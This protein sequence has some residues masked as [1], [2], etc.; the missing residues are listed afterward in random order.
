LSRHAYCARIEILEGRRLCAVESTAGAVANYGS[1]LGTALG[2]VAEW[3]DDAIDN[4]IHMP[5]PPPL[6]GDLYADGPEADPATQG[7]GSGGADLDEFD[8]AALDELYRSGGP[9]PFF[10][11]AYPQPDDPGDGFGGDNELPAYFPAD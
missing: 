5:A 7:P 6:Y 2:N 8:D 4:T 11:V 9:L 10:A 3:A 1:A